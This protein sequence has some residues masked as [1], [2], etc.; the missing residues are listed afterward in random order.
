MDLR[1]TQGVSYLTVA[2]SLV[3]GLPLRNKTAD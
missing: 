3:A 1:E 2:K